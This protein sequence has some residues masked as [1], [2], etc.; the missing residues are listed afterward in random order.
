MRKVLFVFCMLLSVFGYSQGSDLTDKTK[1]EVT[2]LIQLF[3]NLDK[4]G[5]ANAISYPFQREYPIPD[6]ESKIEFVRRFDQVFDAAFVKQIAQ[7]TVDD[8]STVGWR[9]TMF[10]TGELWMNDD[11]QIYRVVHQSSLETMWRKELIKADRKRLHKDVQQYL[12]PIAIF[13]VDHYVARIDEVST[14][15]Y[16]LSMWDATQKMS[17]KPLHIYAGGKMIVEGS[18]NNRILYF[19]NAAEEIEIMLDNPEAK[20][21]NEILYGTG[22]KGS[23]LIYVTGYLSR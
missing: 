6:I 18:M 1:G 9:G 11:G 22:K 13:S 16:R 17:G 12:A 4:E 20:N 23:E 5:I 2:S 21:E 3:A 15:K 14:D 19:E 10:Q 8:W 7:S